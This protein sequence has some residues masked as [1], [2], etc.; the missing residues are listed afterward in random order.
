MSRNGCLRPCIAQATAAPDPRR[1]QPGA[2]A[3]RLPTG[4]RAAARR[5]GRQQP[6]LVRLCHRRGAPDERRLAVA[7]AGA[8]RGH[9][10]GVPGRVGGSPRSWSTTRPSTSAATRRTTRSVRWRRWSARWYPATRSPSPPTPA[11]PARL[12]GRLRQAGQG[13]R[14]RALLDGPRRRRAAVRGV[15]GGRPDREDLTGSRF[16]R[17]AHVRSLLEQGRLD[18]DLRGLG[19][20]SGVLQSL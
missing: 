1:L 15:Q 5:R 14:R 13:A 4:S 17:I 19:G 12:P 18:A 3:T 9:L 16:Q 8:R 2:C 6:G 10:G 11:G 20:R 7:A